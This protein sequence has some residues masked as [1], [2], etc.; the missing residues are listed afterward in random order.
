MRRRYRFWMHVVLFAAKRRGDRLR[1]A[2]RSRL[3]PAASTIQPDDHATT[4]N[5][6]VTWTY[7]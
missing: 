4:G 2:R 6:N 1:Q 3:H 7:T 5:A